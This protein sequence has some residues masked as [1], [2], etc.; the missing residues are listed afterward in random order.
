MH[1]FEKFHISRGLVFSLTACFLGAVVIVVS[2]YLL[3]HGENPLNLSAWIILFTCIPWLFL[4]TKHQKEFKRLSKKNIALLIFIG[5]AS[6]LGI[7]YLQSLA[8]ANTSAINFAFLYRTI[9]IFTIFFAWLF[10]KEPITP[11]KI[12]LVIS[13][14]IG[15]FLLTS[16]GQ[17]IVFT[18]GDI[19]TLMMAASA[20]LV[21]NILIKH[22]ISKMNPELSG[23]VTTTVAG[24]SLVTLSLIAGVFT[25]PQN[26]LLVLLAS[27]FHFVLIIFRNRS[28][29]YAS[30]SFVTLIFALTPL[31]VSILS[32]IFLGETLSTIEMIGGFLIVGS[33]FF[34]ERLKI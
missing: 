8:L 32:F 26:I 19:Y 15:S 30:A 17:S 14:L 34:V 20:A 21:A 4:F 22:T 27:A 23:S 7:N 10:F 5:I 33:V 1:V 24:A 16:N 12:I 11:K 9:I 6:S 25:L 28:Y 18:Q 29:K 3:V 2:R 31:F 13:I